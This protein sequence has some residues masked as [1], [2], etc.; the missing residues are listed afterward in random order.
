MS[1]LS[2]WSLE[3]H[4][5]L[6]NPYFG[7][8]SCEIT[9]DT[10]HI[11]DDGSNPFT[12]ILWFTREGTPAALPAPLRLPPGHRIC[13]A[14]PE[15]VKQG[16][17]AGRFSQFTESGRIL[18][19][20]WEGGEI[21]C[22]LSIDKALIEGGLSPGQAIHAD[23]S[24]VRRIEG[25]RDVSRRDHF[26]IRLMKLA[27]CKETVSLESGIPVPC[28]VYMPRPLSFTPGS[29]NELT[30][31][32]GYLADI[33]LWVPIIKE[34]FQFLNNAFY[35]RGVPESPYGKVL[36]AS[37]AVSL[38]RET[39]WPFTCRFTENLFMNTPLTPPLAVADTVDA[40]PAYPEGMISRLTRA[41][42]IAK[43]V[44]DP[45]S[46]SVRPLST[47]VSEVGFHCLVDSFSL[48]T[49]VTSAWAAKMALLD[50][51]GKNND[52]SSTAWH[53]YNELRESR[54]APSLYFAASKDGLRVGFFT[55]PSAGRE[56]VYL[57][58]I[59]LANA[60]DRE[61]FSTTSVC[62]KVK[63][64]VEEES[65]DLGLLLPFRPWMMQFRAIPDACRE[66]SVGFARGLSPIKGTIQETTDWQN[67]TAMAELTDLCFLEE[68]MDRPVCLVSFF[69]EVLPLMEASSRST[70]RSETPDAIKTKVVLTFMESTDALAKVISDLSPEGTDPLLHP[71]LKRVVLET[72]TSTGLGI[73]RRNGLGEILP[74]FCSQT[75]SQCFL[76]KILDKYLENGSTLT[77]LSPSMPDV[78]IWMAHALMLMGP[79][80]AGICKWGPLHESGSTAARVYNNVL[81]EVPEMRVST[82]AVD[83]SVLASAIILSKSEKRPAMA[84]WWE[85]AGEGVD[86]IV[87]VGG[88]KALLHPRGETYSQESFGYRNFPDDI[89][90]K[91]KGFRIC[92]TPGG[93]EM[94]VVEMQGTAR[95]PASID[96]YSPP[97]QTVTGVHGGQHH[98]GGNGMGLV[99][100]KKAS[101]MAS[102]SREMLLPAVPLVGVNPVEKGAGMTYLQSRKTDSFSKT[103]SVPSLLDASDM[104]KGA[105]L[106]RGATFT[107]KWL[108]LPYSRE[109]GSRCDPGT[110][111]LMVSLNGYCRI[112]AGDRVSSMVTDN[113]DFAIRAVSRE[114]KA[115]QTDEHPDLAGLLIPMSVFTETVEVMKAMGEGSRCRIWLQKAKRESL[116]RRQDVV[117]NPETHLKDLQGVDLGV[118]HPNDDVDQ[119]WR[120]GDYD[121][122]FKVAVATPGNALALTESGGQGRGVFVKHF[123]VLRLLAAMDSL[124]P[125]RL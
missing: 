52:P 119:D 77:S 57:Q 43:I 121:L 120:N 26:A 85:E 90:T 117:Q 22:F 75:T 82:G 47:P 91:V 79:V 112:L 17:R 86:L 123:P 1:F 31:V 58:S 101:G 116:A 98:Q 46:G 33:I 107:H 125:C 68:V 59:A 9:R 73:D 12:D 6:T 37:D 109:G 11:T 48:L 56:G 4:P 53:L 39:N 36:T 16:M 30:T 40:S 78:P 106:M 62:Y 76:D 41:K 25:E 81:M 122:S 54:T 51:A 34:N 83:A 38:C 71:S 70:R 72:C 105:K 99:V 49:A 66:T 124:A 100:L 84:I 32:T 18:S 94:G 27:F 20:P 21:G 60:E 80:P 24:G 65:A 108:E 88:W 44:D 5:V 118:G 115:S 42:D 97:L 92:R 104:E 35:H 69:Q 110:E 3:Q 29:A 103:Q 93:D 113:V 96:L 87:D 23:L 61:W 19:P 74:Y 102:P 15:I 67:L 45:L 14:N 7:L 13:I 89:P 8:S 55:N 111:F 114:F 50:A 2:Q 95:L 63:P 64:I 10:L 28:K